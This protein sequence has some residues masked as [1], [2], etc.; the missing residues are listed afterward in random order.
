MDLDRLLR[1]KAVAVVGGAEAERVVEQLDLLGFTGRVWPIH[2]TRPEMR[3]RNSVRSPDDLP[4]PPD[5]AFVAVPRESA[6][7][8]VAALAGL[9]T[10]SAVV[11]TSGFAE[12]GDRELQDELVAAAGAMPILG[13]NCYGYVNALD[14]T[15]IWPDVHGLAPVDR[16]VAIITQS[17]NIGLN[18]TMA[19]RGLDIGVVITAGN[20]A[21]LDVST[22]LDALLD[23]P[24]I[25]GIGIQLE[26]VAD[27]VA[28]GRV[29]LRA[30][31]LGT[32][33]VA[34][35]MGSSEKGGLVTAS[36]TGAL[37]GDDDAYRA[38]F[39]R[40]GVAQV[41]TLP[42]FL[43]TLKLAG[44]IP[45]RPRVVSLSASGGE[46]AHVAD[47]AHDA[48]V[49]LPELT[50]DH[51]AAITATLGP[52]VVVSNPMDYHTFSWGD[53][54][55]I[56]ATFASVLAGS[57][58][59][60]ML[61]L[62]FPHGEAPAAWWAACR[63]FAAASGAMPGLVVSSLPETMPP[64][65]QDRLRRMGLIPMLGIAETIEAIAALGVPTPVHDVVHLAAPPI[66][67]APT[68]LD[69]VASKRWLAAAGITVP[70]GVRTGEPESTQPPFPLT[71]K[72]LG[73][74]H[75]T[76]VAGVAVGIHN[77]AELE[78]RLAV[79]PSDDGYLFEETVTDGVLELLVGVRPVPHMGWLLTLGAGGTL[80]EVVE[81]R[82][83]LLAP[84]SRKAIAG[85]LG[86]LR[87]VTGCRAPRSPALEAAVD[88]A[89]AL[90]SLCEHDG[91]LEIEVNPLIVTPSRA[92]AVDAMVTL[93]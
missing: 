60:A 50:P 22:L 75:K 84:A 82:V 67:V 37:V 16:G 8:I 54:D 28:F 73:I 49:D 76:E 86:R 42:T 66:P 3:G 79:M 64:A 10:G 43:A 36:H 59:V 81:D 48:G 15:A 20:Q 56:R 72:V 90:Q 40:Y 21:V 57:F 14:G 7:S 88:A 70:A 78:A 39:A 6:P 31:D 13:P 68:T 85:A 26:S 47:L 51:A 46:A 18:L 27:S 53:E 87:V 1:P 33:L 2:P 44:R 58:Q 32:P 92:V 55:R 91:A 45:P 17:G 29:A 35:R 12:S 38:L 63:A 23:D 52:L 62:D 30:H 65:A 83:H 74:D 11:Y 9:G 41:R 24:R 61:V 89:V 93:A 71:V 34:L 80:V 77:A 19:R 5:V 69:E 4:A 25:T